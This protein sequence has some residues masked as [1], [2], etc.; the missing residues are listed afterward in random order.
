[1]ADSD[2]RDWRQAKALLSTVIW[3]WDFG[4]EEFVNF[5]RLAVQ[6]SEP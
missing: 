3:P 5:C 6:E 1:M 4:Q 2:M